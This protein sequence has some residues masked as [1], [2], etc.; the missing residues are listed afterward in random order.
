M[1]KHE[2]MRKATHHANM[3]K[4]LRDW[5]DFREYMESECVLHK[6]VNRDWNE[7]QTQFVQLNGKREALNRVKIHAQNV[8]Q[9]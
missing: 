2:V 3:A 8:K 4:A 7:K 9:K 5:F 6:I 1:I